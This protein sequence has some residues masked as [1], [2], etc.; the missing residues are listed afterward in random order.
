[1]EAKAKVE[2]KAKMTEQ[3]VDGVEVLEETE[4]ME[5][6]DSHSDRSYATG[7]ALAFA[8]GAVVGVGIAVTWIPERSRRRVGPTIVKG[9]QRARRAGADA[10]DEAR[11]R[12][13]DLA[14]EF[15]EELA[16][17]LEAARE[18]FSDIA[19][20]Q[21]TSAKKALKREYSRLRG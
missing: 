2:M 17:N 8:I 20:K 13:R 1:M 14:A 16:S 4:E 19:R 18:E 12:S 21:V 10:L 5:E 7:L 15:R 3:N 11:R 9:Y 6:A